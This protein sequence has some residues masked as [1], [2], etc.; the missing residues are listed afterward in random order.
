MTNL[1][2]VLFTLALLI[3]THLMRTLLALRIPAE[4][5]FKPTKLTQPPDIVADLLAQADQ[6]LSD[7]GFSR[8][9]WA[10]V[11]TTPP[12]PGFSAPLI[13]LYHHKRQPI[14]ARVSPPHSIFSTD[15]CQVLLL[16]MSK[17]KTFLATTN[18]V[19]ELF[20]HPPERLSI[21]L[22]SRADTIAGQFRD[23]ILEMSRRGL[24]WL[25]RSEEKGEWAWVFRLANR[26][27]R[28][29]IQWLNN[30]G[31][32]KRLEDG[33]AVP[34]VGTVV[35]FI[36]RFIT[37]R[38]KKP[39]Q[40][41]STLP[42]NQAAYLF[43]NW[44]LV[45][46]LPPTVSTQLGLFIV[47]TLAFVLLAGLLWNWTIALLLLGVISFHEVGHWLA[48]RFLDYRNLHIV[49]PPLIGGVTLSQE[50]S[51]YATHRFLISLMGPLP[52]I[53]LGTAVL[54][55]YGQ[56]GGWISD[57][58]VIL[59]L[60]NYL[61]LLPIIPLDGSRLLKALTPVKQFGL[62]IALNW[63]VA[64]ALL[65]LG[66]LTNSLFLAAMVLAP[67]FSALVWLRRKRVLDALEGVADGSI[68]TEHNEQIASIIQAIDE[69]D[70]RYRPL[71]KK[72][73]EITDILSMLRVKAAAPR[74]AGALLAL[75]L[76]TL[77]LPPIAVL[78]ISPGMQNVTK[79]F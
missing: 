45:N 54:L 14:I 19:P 30:S 52:G 35:R 43:H 24:T 70:K 73:R 69:T 29:S 5:R 10:T 68:H 53:I 20:P 41:R 12:L 46:R 31:S 22:R 77:L 18:R 39:S 26:Y 21:A 2:L 28:K 11:Q 13:R 59:L 17:G 58:G 40:E 50:S 42:S 37:G 63:L 25:D 57:L 51:Y 65:L 33:S 66:W 1:L 44:Q 4:L 60:V 56:Q 78:A 62:L 15:R 48:M 72:V 16:S 38:E 9:H 75:Y 23:H 49:T 71:E 27:E 76:A 34:R 74:V 47:S 61:N 36:W 79:L 64:A 6:A 55:I 67:L 7:L 32:I 8:G 3:L